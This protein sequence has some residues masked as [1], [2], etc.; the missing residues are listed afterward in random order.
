MSQRVQN[1]PGR[2][3]G[4]SLIELLLVLVILSVL[5]AIVVPRFT[6]VSEKARKSK[7]ESDISNMSTALSRFEIEVGRYPSSDEGLRALVEQPS[8]LPE[9][10]WG[11]PYLERG[12]PSDPWGKPYNYRSPGLNNPSYDLYSFGPDGREGGDDI[13]NW[14]PI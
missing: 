3:G 2:P 8:G 6:G 4:F 7:A 12:V 11:G 5:A 1:T 14:S 10:K 13:T 9:G